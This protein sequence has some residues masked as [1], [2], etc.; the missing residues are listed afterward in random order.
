MKVLSRTGYVIWGPVQNENVGALF[1]KY[2]VFQSE[3]S[4]YLSTGPVG[5]HGVLFHE[6]EDPRAPF[7]VST[8]THLLVIRP[9]VSSW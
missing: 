9:A 6:A 4:I 7:T 8:S 1:K 2:E 5:Q 3:K